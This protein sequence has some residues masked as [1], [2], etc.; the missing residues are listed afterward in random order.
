MKRKL[1]LLRRGVGMALLLLAPSAYAQW[2]QDLWVGKQA[3]NWCDSYNKGINFS[4]G[5][6]VIFTGVQLSALEGSTTI[7]DVN[8]ELLFYAGQHK[9]WNKNHQIMLNGNDLLGGGDSSTQSGVF[10]QKPGSTNIYYLFNVNTPDAITGLIYSEIDLTLASG[11]GG[12]TA[13]KN[14]MLDNMVGV[15]KITAVHHADGEG[16]WVITHRTGS[17]E[18]VAYLVTSA[19]VTTTPVVSAV[20]T[21]YSGIDPNDVYLAGNNGGVGQLKASPDGTKLAAAILDGTNKG[22]DLLDFDNQTGIVSNAKHLSDNTGLVYGLEFSPNSRFLY[23][24]DPSGGWVFGGTVHQYDATLGTEADVAVSNTII[25]TLPSGSA[26][27]SC[28]MQLGPDGKIYIKDVVGEVLNAISYPNNQGVAAGFTAAAINLGSSIGTPAFIQSYFESGILAEE[29]CPG[30]IA[31][32]LLR[33]PDATSITWDFGDPASGADNISTVAEHSYTTG[34]TYTVTATITSNGATQTATGQVIVTNPNGNITTP[35]AVTLCA[36]A[37]GTATF[38]L[39]LQT[40]IILGSLDATLYTVTY[41]PTVADALADTNE[42]TTPAAFTSAG[43]TIY[44]SVTHNGNNCTSYTQFNVVASPAP[45]LPIVPDLET[46]DTAAIDGFAIFNLTQQDALLLQGLTGAN[47]AYYTTEADA[48]SGTNAITTPASFTNTVN[49][50]TIYATV[51]TTSGCHSVTSFSI[52]VLPAL[53]LPSVGNLQECD[54]NAQDGITNFDLTQQDGALLSGITGTVAYYTTMAD[55]QG[56]VN[57]VIFPTNFPNT[58]NPQNI[59]AVVTNSTTGC[60]GTAIFTIE[61]L[62]VPTAT[63]VSD[64]QSCTN[65][66]NLIVHTASLQGQSG[67]TVAYFTS[68][69]NAEGN[70]NALA[71]PNAFESTGTIQTIYTRISSGDCYTV[72]T[73]DVITLPAPQ[74]GGSLVIEGCPPF[75]LGTAVSGTGLSFSYYTSQEDADNNINAIANPLA[76]EITTGNLTVY[77]RAET[78]DGCEAFAEIELQTGACDIPKGISPNRDGFNDTF[79]L[80]YFDVQKLSVFNRYG[81]EVYTRNNYTNQWY[82]QQENGKELPTGTYYYVVELSGGINKTGWVYINRQEN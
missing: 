45:V 72:T 6:P 55:A 40:P 79:D 21:A 53:Q 57:P 30:D 31:F 69:A 46:C 75:N 42:I 10:V 44:V 27:G 14:I 59:Y 3:Y 74:I 23:V 65:V 36:D 17:A 9:I 34:G 8:G 64:L 81:Q 39:S 28:A 82:G 47:I 80:S 48:H 18:F 49:P 38:N 51:T 20:G 56:G 67:Y 22:V 35:T 5:S 60:T 7:S 29:G 12:V 33:I 15:E 24:S 68:L 70:I 37:N 26:Y 11:L 61:A 13:N 32:T 77:V 2:Q 71:T 41:Y 54:T 1:Q 76:Y 25:A 19:G 4:S 73:F 58:S 63:A 43:Q 52:D 78:T 62:P 50:Q 66:F 16:V